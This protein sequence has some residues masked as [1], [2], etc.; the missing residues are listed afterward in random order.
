MLRAESAAQITPESVTQTTPESA[1]QFIPRV[2]VQDILNSAS[3]SSLKSALQSVLDSGDQLIPKST[4]QLILE[5]TQPD[6][7]SAT[8]PDLEPATQPD[9]RS[10]IRFS[11]SP[12]PVSPLPPLPSLGPSPESATQPSPESVD[13]RPIYPGRPE[14]IYQRYLADKVAWLRAHPDVRPAQYRKARG[15]KQYSKRCLNDNRWY[16]GPQRLVLETE[17]FIEPA[18][19]TDEEVIA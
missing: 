1:S 16:L 5:L 3:Q 10:F 8:Q 2:T 6:P 9:P 4:I 19:W 14:L 17:T 7:E 15:L 11:R 12:S 18:K 13:T